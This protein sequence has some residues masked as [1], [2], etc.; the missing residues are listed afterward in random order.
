MENPF[1]NRTQKITKVL[2]RS[3]NMSSEDRPNPTQEGRVSRFWE[4]TPSKV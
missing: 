4:L 2:N 1:Q 3:R